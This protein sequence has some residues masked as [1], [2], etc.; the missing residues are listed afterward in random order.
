MFGLSTS[1]IKILVIGVILLTISSTIYA[2]YTFVS[3]LQS[4]N[5]RLSTDNATLTANNATLVAGTLV[6]QEAIASLHR[7]NELQMVIFQDTTDAFNLSR[8]QVDTLQERLGRH[9]LGYLAANKP[10][11]VENVINKAT[12]AVGRCFEIA[13]GSPLTA[14]ERNA[15]LTSRT[16]KE[17]PALANPNYK[18]K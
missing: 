17:C 9:E 6:Q 13:A 16:N 10:A 1:W 12:K 7:D 14:E 5:H 3:D 2:G 11:L 18:G 4:E 8:Q 15:T